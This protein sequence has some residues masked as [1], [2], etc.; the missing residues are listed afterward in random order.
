MSAEKHTPG[1]KKG[2]LDAGNDGTGKSIVSFLPLLL[3]LRSD[4][5][6]IDNAI[7]T[8][9]QL[10]LRREWTEQD[11]TAQQTRVVASIQRR[12]QKA[13][14]RMSIRPRASQLNRAPSVAV[15]EDSR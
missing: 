9:E 12:L 6:T 1:P 7:S 3:E 5:R 14:D 2:V 4:L 8:Y 13:C 10:C 15:R 11:V